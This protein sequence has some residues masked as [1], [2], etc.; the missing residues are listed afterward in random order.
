[1]VLER[2]D[3]YEVRLCTGNFKPSDLEVA[4]SEKRLT[5]RARQGQNSW[6]RML[7]FA[8]PVDT[9]KVTARWSDRVLTIIL[10]KKRKA[11]AE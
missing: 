7:N 11:A 4:A 3:V 2:Q 10:P 5:V 8:E 6:E 9:G 1:M